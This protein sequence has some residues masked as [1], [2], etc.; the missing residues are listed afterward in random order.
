MKKI[1]TQSQSL[2]IPV[3]SSLTQIYKLIEQ[4]KNQIYVRSS[5]TVVGDLETGFST[6]WANGSHENGLSFI[7]VSKQGD[8]ELLEHLEYIAWRLSIY[9]TPKGGYMIW[10]A[11]GEKAGRGSDEEPLLQNVVPLGIVSRE[12][13]LAMNA[14]FETL[15]TN[16]ERQTPQQKAEV[17]NLLKKYK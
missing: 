5:K 3:L 9:Y 6:N 2:S 17:E 4:N 16:I 12:L 14:I 15:N 13:S 7:S 1:L 8:D 10:L 11:T